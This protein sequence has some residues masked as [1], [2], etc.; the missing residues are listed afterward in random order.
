MF[1][2]DLKISSLRLHIGPAGRFLT[3]ISLH[4]SIIVTQGDQANLTYDNE[5]HN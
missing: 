5:R 3:D 4:N 1:Y 2:T